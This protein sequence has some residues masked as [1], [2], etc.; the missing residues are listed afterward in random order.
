MA[1]SSILRPVSWGLRRWVHTIP[2]GLWLVACAD[3]V[4]STDEYERFCSAAC[5]RRVECSSESMATCRSDCE[6]DAEL[7]RVNGALRAR[8][9]ECL[10]RSD[11]DAVVSGRAASDCYLQAAAATPPS[12]ICISFCLEDAQATF[13]CGGSRSVSDCVEGAAC[14]QS[15]TSLLDAIACNHMQ[16]CQRREQCLQEAL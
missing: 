12:S 1:A 6:G 16:D 13:E 5:A 9:G 2:H 10:E 8:Q 15:D 3:G 11:C 14:E 4:P 7:R